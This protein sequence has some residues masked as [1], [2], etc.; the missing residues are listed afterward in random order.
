MVTKGFAAPEVGEAYVRAHELC[1]RVGD[2][3][4]QFIAHWGLFIHRLVRADH[5]TSLTMARQLIRPAEKL[6]EAH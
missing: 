4:E 1:E 3:K 5:H 2:T 6:P